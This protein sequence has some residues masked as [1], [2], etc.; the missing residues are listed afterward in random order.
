MTKDEN[1]TDKRW[2]VDIFYRRMDRI[3]PVRYY[4]EE[5]SELAEI[6]EQ[7]PSFRAIERIEINLSRVA[8]EPVVHLPGFRIV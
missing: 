1:I 2:I 8:G 6:V 4:I 3:M 5:L 7:G